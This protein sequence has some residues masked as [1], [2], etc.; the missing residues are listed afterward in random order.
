MIIL[1][2]YD[3]TDHFEEFEE[4]VENQTSSDKVREFIDLINSDN[5]KDLKEE[6]N[7][8]K[9][10]NRTYAKKAQIFKDK[11]AAYLYSEFIK[12]ITTDKIKGVP[13]SRK[14]I[15]NKIAIWSSKN[16]IHHS[17]ITGQIEGSA[18]SFFVLTFSF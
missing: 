11:L 13:I 15:P 18:H 12:F 1:T 17:H 16:C 3:L 10:P 6:V 14:F 7:R 2:K 8:V 9:I 4:F 5:F